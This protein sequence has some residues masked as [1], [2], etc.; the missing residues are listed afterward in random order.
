[1][2][3]ALPFLS[4]ATVSA[5]AIA[6]VPLPS[7]VQAFI[8]QRD[9]CD[10]FRGEPWDTGN[11]P[12]AKERREFIL[13]NIKKLCPGTDKRLADLRRKYRNTPDIMD[14]LRNYEDSIE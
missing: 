1:M 9:G 2:K 13:Q 10:H 8:D 11:A 6:T 14:R 3:L 4:L 5:F 7:D 12:E